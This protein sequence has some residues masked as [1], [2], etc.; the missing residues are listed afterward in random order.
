MTWWLARVDRRARGGPRGRAGDGRLGLGGRRIHVHLEPE[1]HRPVERDRARR[2]VAGVDDAATRAGG[3]SPRVGTGRHDAV[4]RPRR[5][6]AA[7]RRGAPRRGCA[8]RPPGA[9]RRRI[10]RFG[11]AG[12]AIVAL[13]FLPLVVH[14]LTTDFSEVERRPR[15]P[16][17]RRRPAD[18]RAARP[19]PRHRGARRV[20]AADRAA[21][22]CSDRGAR[23]GRSSSSRSPCGAGRSASL[24]ERQARSLARAS[25]CSGRPACLTFIS[26]SLATVVPGLPNDHYHAFADPMVFTLIG[27]GAAVLWRG[28]VRHGD[29]GGAAAGGDAGRRSRP[30][31][32]PVAPAGSWPSSESW[33]GR[34]QPREPAAG[35]P[36]GRRLPG[37]RPGGCPDHRRAGGGRADAP[38]A[39]RLQVDRGLRLS[40]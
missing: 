35:R 40:R 11:L 24:R 38:L 37:R 20:V 25:G 16:A 5:D 15:L 30:S 26:P 36:P 9:E 12:L 39:P 14:E 31:R 17:R 10:W 13:S 23:R 7:D 8:R 6:D 18:A 4:P 28:G 33:P 21:H 34:V 29:A 1:P 27:M 32:R 3:C 2:R 22:R 19:V